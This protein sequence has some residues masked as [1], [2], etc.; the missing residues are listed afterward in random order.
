MT[1][2]E[3]RKISMNKLS[4]K[5]CKNLLSKKKKKCFGLNTRNASENLMDFL[6][7]SKENNLLYFEYTLNENKNLF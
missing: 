4:F 2:S 6:N 7:Q 5:E 3:I 1:P